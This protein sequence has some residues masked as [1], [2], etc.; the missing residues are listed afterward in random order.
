MADGLPY[1]KFNVS[2][3][4]SGKITLEKMDVQGLFINISA[5]YWQREGNLTLTETKRRLTQVKPKAFD[6]LIESGLI[7]LKG[8]N[9]T[10]NYLDEQLA[11][12]KEKHEINKANGL[13]GGRPKKPKA[14]DSLTE[15]KG[16][17]R[18][19]IR[20][21]EIRE[22]TPPQKPVFY[23][24][25]Q[26]ATFA[27]IF[28]KPYPKERGMKAEGRDV[29]DILHQLGPGEWLAQAKAMRQVYEI[30]GWS[31]PTY[32]PTIVQSLTG[33]DWIERL[34]DSD[35]ERK[36]ERKLNTKLNGPAELPPLAP[37]NRP[38]ALDI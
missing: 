15:T 36:A 12:R 3:W 21:E 30:E 13:L 20:R 27:K 37:A 31:V 22:D 8:D 28:N 38:G 23:T 24:F 17:R 7:K 33:T 14:F 35:P 4:I 34:K 18:E 25:E 16:N 26:R 32:P 19:E 6:S 1:F 2:A 11:E 10:I 29:D 5:L 9:L